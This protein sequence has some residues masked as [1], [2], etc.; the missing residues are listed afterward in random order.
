ML[1]LGLPVTGLAGIWHG[2]VAVRYPRRYNPSFSARVLLYLGRSSTQQYSKARLFL[3]SPYQH[4]DRRVP[5]S[6]EVYT[7]R[8]RKH[9]NVVPH[10]VRPRQHEP[11]NGT[12]SKRVMVRAA[13]TTLVELG[14]SSLPNKPVHTALNFLCPVAL[15]HEHG[16][17]RLNA[18]GIR[19]NVSYGHD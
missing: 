6:A 12:D 7:D 3:V 13:S 15:D 14:L 17:V 1:T 8:T 9:F 5:V 16:S 10:A 4:A 19:R 2:N 18:C 11:Q